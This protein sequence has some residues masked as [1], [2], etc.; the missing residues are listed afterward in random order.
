MLTALYNRM[1]GWVVE[2]RTAD[3]YL[4]MFILISV[5]LLTLLLPTSSETDQGAWAS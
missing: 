2:G 4:E 3:D 1:T 5:K